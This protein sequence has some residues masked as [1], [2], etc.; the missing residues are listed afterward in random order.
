MHRLATLVL[1]LVLVAGLMPWAAP[2]VESRQS[3]DQIVV[4]R[5]GVVSAARVGV[6]AADLARRHRLDVTNTYDTVLRGFAAR[7]PDGELDRLRRDPRVAF[8]EPD[9]PTR[10]FAEVL[11]TGVDRIGADSA[12]EGEAPTEPGE[13]VAILDTGIDRDH[14]DLNVAGGYNCTSRDRR[15]WGDRYGHGTHVAGIVGAKHNRRGVVGVAPGTPLFAVKVIN[16]RGNG[17]ISWEICGLEW[18]V[19]RGITIANMSFGGR[20]PGDFRDLCDSSAEHLAV[21]AAA[22]AGVRMTVAAGNDGEDAGDYT[23]AMYDQVITVSALVDTDGCAG[24]DGGVTLDGPDDALAIFSNRG[25]VVDVA[26]PG[27]AILSTFK[28]GKYAVFWGTSMAA[29]H[30]AGALARG[31]DGTEEAGPDRDTDGFAEG[32]LHLSDN[33][34]CQV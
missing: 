31:W 23:P 20:S 7:I 21:C 9:R 33:T 13:P 11:P 17:L 3:R 19:K 24:G 8:V 10:V 1:T 15:A 32:I 16:D 6:A 22:A 34:A 25:A 4:L 26:A 29:P 14:P 12:A 28:N 2:T 18:T 5:D 30:V 27:A